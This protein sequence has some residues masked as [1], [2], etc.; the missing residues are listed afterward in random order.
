MRL[1]LLQ[2]TLCS[3][4]FP[5][6]PGDAQ[7]FKESNTSPQ[8]ITFNTQIVPGCNT[9]NRKTILQNC[10]CGPVSSSPEAEIP[11]GLV[12]KPMSADAASYRLMALIRVSL[13]QFSASHKK[14]S[15]WLKWQGKYV[16]LL[17][18]EPVCPPLWVPFIMTTIS[19]CSPSPRFAIYKMRAITLLYTNIL[20][21]RDSMDFCNCR[22]LMVKQQNHRWDR[23]SSPE[24][25]ALFRKGDKSSSRSEKK[26]SVFSS[27]WDI[28]CFL[29]ISATPSVDEHES[30]VS[31]CSS[32]GLPLFLLDLN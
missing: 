23:W 2:E 11:K 16:Q 3:K 26:E 32:L 29:D 13:Q 8:N 4:R 28:C 20:W 19:W 7:T 21:L 27:K 25:R 5:I 14:S 1:L 15:E 30:S 12:S 24:N 10:A 9:E 17:P 6:K 18:G 22:A 31:V